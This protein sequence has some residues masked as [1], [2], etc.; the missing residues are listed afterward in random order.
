MPPS[1]Q[2]PLVHNHPL[3]LAD[4]EQEDI[5]LTTGCQ[6]SHLCSVGRLVSV[7][8][9]ADDSGVARSCSSGPGE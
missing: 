1:L 3:G 7:C 4:V 5:V 6:G 9:A 8:D 2:P